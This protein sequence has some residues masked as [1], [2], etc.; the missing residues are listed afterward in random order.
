MASRALSGPAYDATSDF[1]P[2]VSRGLGLEIVRVTV[3]HNGPANDIAHT[4]TAGHHL[5]VSLAVI[6]EQRRK[7]AGMSG[8]RRFFGI[9]VTTRIGKAAAA[10]ISTFVDMKSKE[11]RI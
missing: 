4:K 10:A 11:A 7:V 3:Y 6:A 8:M 1:L 9:V 2:C 5:A